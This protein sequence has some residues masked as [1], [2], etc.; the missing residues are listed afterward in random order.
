MAAMEH[1]WWWLRC[2]ELTDG[3]FGEVLW[4]ISGNDEHPAI[5]EQGTS[6]LNGF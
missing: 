6:V 3:Q 5:L 2:R 1:H 4:G